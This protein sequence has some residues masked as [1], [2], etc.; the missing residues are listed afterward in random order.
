MTRKINVRSRLAVN[1]PIL[2]HKSITLPSHQY[3]CIISRITSYCFYERTWC[4]YSI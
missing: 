2:K 1:R 4:Q 3:I